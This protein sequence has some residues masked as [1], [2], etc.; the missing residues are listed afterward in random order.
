MTANSKDIMTTAA[1]LLERV[2]NN[3]CDEEAL[4]K[5]QFAA[6]QLRLF[7]MPSNCRRYSPML[8]SAALV[9]DSISPKLYDDIYNS[10]LLVLPHRSTLRKLTAALNIKEHED[11]TALSTR[12]RLVNF[13]M[14]EVLK[15]QLQEEPSFNPSERRDNFAMDEVLKVQLQEEPSFNPSERRDNFA[16]DMVLKEELKDETTFTPSE[17][18]VNVAIDN[19]QL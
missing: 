2:S 13:A 15:V 4:N 16:M 11:E 7:C 17:R 9:W 12:E 3:G 10:S 19:V 14:D 18:R 6:E 1:D 5:C 8:M